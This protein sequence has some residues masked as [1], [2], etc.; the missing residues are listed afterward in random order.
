MRLRMVKQNY[1]NLI[2][3]FPHEIFLM[4]F[5]KQQQTHFKYTHVAYVVNTCGA[6]S[7]IIKIISKIIK[8]FSYLIFFPPAIYS[9]LVLT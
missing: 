9:F 7:K 6:V 2:I 8:I 4:P 3:S 1:L 5:H